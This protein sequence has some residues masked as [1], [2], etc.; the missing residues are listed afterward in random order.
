MHEKDLIRQYKEL[1]ASNPDAFDVVIGD[2]L[3]FTKF[4]KASYVRGDSYQTA[5]NEGKKIVFMRIKDLLKY[6]EEDI[7]EIERI[8]RKPLLEYQ[9]K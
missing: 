8:N 6:T 9:L 7:D 4:N 2:L 5:Y 3:K 1:K